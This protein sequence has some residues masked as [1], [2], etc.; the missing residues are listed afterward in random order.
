MSRPGSQAVAGFFPTPAHLVPR[1]AG[2]FA[3][4]I[5]GMSSPCSILDPCAGT[6]AAVDGILEY[7][8]GS[9]RHSS[10][11]RRYLCE[12]EKT[13]YDDL[14]AVTYDALHGDAF[15][16]DFARGSRKG[17]DILYLNPPYDTDRECGRMEERFLERF[18]P[19]VAV[20][21]HTV[22]VVPHYALAASVQTLALNYDEVYCCRFPDSDFEAYR[23]IVLVA[24]RGSG[25][26]AADA[27]IVALV[28]SWAASV[29]GMPVLPEAPTSVFRICPKDQ[30]STGL[31]R[32]QQRTVDF[33]RLLRGFR[34]WT[35]APRGVPVLTPTVVPTV[36]VQDMLLR[37]YPVA[38]PPRPAHIA[39]GIAAGIFN[40][41]RIEPNDGQKLPALLVKGVFDRE[42]RT[43][44][45]K[46]DKEG[47]TKS[48][49][50]V[51]QPRL[52]TTVLDLSTHKYH[53]LGDTA[54]TNVQGVEDLGV[55][56]LLTMYGTSLMRAMERQCPIGYDPRRDADTIEVPAAARRPYTAQAH[57]VRA[58]VH[59]LGGPNV[60]IQKRTRKAAFLLGEI[61]SGKTLCALLAIRA[62]GAERPLVMCPPH[63]LTS[64][65]NE[66]AATFPDMTAIVLQ[67][68]H[69]L[70][71][72]TALNGPKIGILSRETAKLSHGWVGVQGACPR[73]GARVPSGDLAKKR[74]RCDAR[75]II[76][77]NE[78]AR[79]VLRMARILRP[80]SP[81]NTTIQHLLSGRFDQLMSASYEGHTT[82]VPFTALAWRP[83]VLAL[84][85][86]RSTLDTEKAD[87]AILFAL[88]AV[89]DASFTVEM[90]REAFKVENQGHYS[91]LSHCMA[92]LLP[93]EHPVTDIQAEAR[94]LF[95]YGPWTGSYG[96]HDTSCNLDG[97][98]VQRDPLVLDRMPAGSLQVAL[99][100]LDVAAT[101]AS[102]QR[103]TVCHEPLFQAVPE[104][105]RI[106]LA[107]YIT[108]RHAQ[109]FDSLIIDECHEYASAASA[110]G[111]AAT[112]LSNLN[113][114]TIIMTGTVTNG[115]ADSMFANMWAINREFREE[116]DRDER[117]KFVDRFGYRKRIVDLKDDD[118]E[119]P[120]EFGS[121]T[122]RVERSARVVGDA[123]GVLPLFLLRYLLPVSVTLHKADLAI[124][125]PDCRQIRHEIDPTPEQMLRYN[126]LRSALVQQIKKDR[127]VPERA[128]RLFGQLAELPSYLDRA[129]SDTGNC[130]DGSFEIRYPESL[131]NELVAMQT[132]FASDVLM[133]K[134]QWLVDLVEAEL[135]EGRNVMVFSWHL[136]LLPR[137]SRLL[138]ARTGEKAT[139]L[140]ADKVPTAKRQSWIDKEIVR[141]GRRVMCTNPVAIQTGLNN[142]VHF[143]TVIWMENPACNPIVYR[144]AI[145]RI[146]RIGQKALETRVHFPF[147]RGTMQ[148]QMHNLLLR[149]V[150]ISVSTDGLDPESSLQAAGVGAE[151]Y[152]AGL[153]IGK[154][155]WRLMNESEAGAS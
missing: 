61:G 139:I 39:A 42:Y 80:A 127:F 77:P 33:T 16:V 155:L 144:Q 96:Q 76:A 55:Q 50:Q 93:V 114:P 75:A 95:T 57:A 66:I 9:D 105:R 82:V 62:C 103:G 22:F 48:L 78:V 83:L 151:S 67:S 119:D 102:F 73:C 60:P 2:L 79:Q 59:L 145:G 84:L 18:T 117:S 72:F 112:R 65:T 31:D 137:L 111:H 5:A 109:T 125:L 28:Q 104:P 26:L 133:P 107:K 15:H 20:G 106:G 35:T 32:W 123:P 154:E 101:A 34:P 134:E 143:S 25:A 99:R 71:A 51:Q 150:A 3:P 141:K 49:V 148:D 13:R 69:D 135:A 17:V 19:A 12:L 87:R 47:N 113:L 36:P 7:L 4:L 132:P 146:D 23:Q 10:Y 124:D 108:Q 46:K 121:V 92:R 152:Q 52:I 153:S 43:V 38:T 29:E 100:A 131:S 1:I 147:Y 56:D 98:Q 89:N 136:N 110:Q 68:P 122:D 24:R 142:L 44:E 140:W 115:Y 54:G 8:T 81:Q 21:G 91:N 27:T 41:S 63:L 85:A 129:T 130:D 88:S 120:K 149:K 116:F 86:Y 14:K 45:E 70:E 30:W 6:G 37:T 126:N 74:A 97:I 11:Q 118:H 128:G 64:W 90:V 40:G 58:L 53:T 138:E 94:A